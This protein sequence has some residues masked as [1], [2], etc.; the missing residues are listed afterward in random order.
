MDRQDR[1]QFIPL[2]PYRVPYCR[3]RGVWRCVYDPASHLLMSGGADASIKI[4]S[5]GAHLS[6]ELDPCGLP[7]ETKSVAE[8]AGSALPQRGISE[9]EF[10]IVPPWSEAGAPKQGQDS[11]AEYVRVVHVATPQVGHPAG[12]EQDLNTNHELSCGFG[13]KQL[14][15]VGA[16]DG[17]L[18]VASEVCVG[19]GRSR[20][21]W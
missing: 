19:R 1:I 14:V 4:F 7:S 8:S 17:N 11:K 18:I 21:R 5:L 16:R 10:C 9:R 12:T 2:D 6:P 13:S 3:G 20:R 15:F